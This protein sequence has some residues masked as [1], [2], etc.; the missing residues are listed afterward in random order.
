M[1]K[2]ISRFGQLFFFIHNSKLFF[3]EQVARVKGTRQHAKKFGQQASKLFE[4][5]RGK[6]RVTESVRKLHNYFKYFA[7]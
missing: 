7:V 6:L 4:Y 1:K 2:H 5:W 3:D